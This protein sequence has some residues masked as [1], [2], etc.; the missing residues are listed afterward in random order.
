MVGRL[1]KINKYQGRKILYIILLLVFSL[2][3]GF[4]FVNHNDY[5]GRYKTEIV[6][7]NRKKK[8][9]GYHFL[10]FHWQLANSLI[11]KLSFNFRIRE[12]AREVRVNYMIQKANFTKV[13]D[14]LSEI[15]QL[16]S[17]ERNPGH[18]GSSP[19]C[20]DNKIQWHWQ[21]RFQKR[22]HSGSCSRF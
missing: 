7:S 19:P 10:N 4:A 21:W 1:K 16:F 15:L 6:V 9:V 5:S 8:F 13:K 3:L 11:N 12:Y 18:A 17:D 22:Q 20:P 2:P 14:Y